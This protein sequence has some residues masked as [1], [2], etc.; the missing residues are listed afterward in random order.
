LGLSGR[1]PRRVDAATKH[2]LLGLVE[3]AVAGG[4]TVRCAVTTLE[5]KERR[6]C[7]GRDI[8]APAGSMTYRRVAGGR[9]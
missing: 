7:A 4:W 6:V 5:I 9:R 2:E 8:A 3:H 1:I